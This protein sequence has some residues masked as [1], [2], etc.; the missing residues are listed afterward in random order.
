MSKRIFSLLGLVALMV[1]LSSMLSA[2]APMPV[3]TFEL[4]QGLPSAMNVG[5]TYTVIVQVESDQPFL[6]AAALPDS[7]YP[8]RGVVPVQGGDHVGRNTSAT[9]SVTFV[10]KGTTSKMANG[11]APVSV[12]AGVR[13]S[14]GYVAAQRYDFLVQ[15][16]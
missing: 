12:V 3:T 11:L 6:Y 1:L 2:A 8:G 15:V 9:L 4:V 16:P 14:G 13:Y 7:Y 5:D 10:A